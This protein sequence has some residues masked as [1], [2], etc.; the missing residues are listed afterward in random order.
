MA[1]TLDFDKIKDWVAVLGLIKHMAYKGP[2]P[3]DLQRKYERRGRDALWTSLKIGPRPTIPA[4]T[5][6]EA[7]EA[8]FKIIGD[9]PTTKES[10]NWT[11][12]K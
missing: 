4:E 3:L 10:F 1:A 7:E 9:K 2:D 11:M 5:V 8:A 12:R 6:E